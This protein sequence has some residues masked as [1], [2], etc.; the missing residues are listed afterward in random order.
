MYCQCLRQDAG[1]PWE[2]LSV[3]W[4]FAGLT[5]TAFLGSDAALQAQH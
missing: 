2:A 4:L 1:L 3:V 5:Q